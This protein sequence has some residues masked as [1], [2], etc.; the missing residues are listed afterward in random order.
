[1]PEETVVTEETTQE[2]VPVMAR[3][4]SNGGPVSPVKCSDS[5][6]ANN[7]IDDP[8]DFKSDYTSDASLFDIYRDK[9]NN[10][11]WLGNKSQ[12]IWIPCF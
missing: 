9:N 10:K 1:M 3:G 2:L 7:G 12:T 8:E 6:L 4:C 11:L 5:W